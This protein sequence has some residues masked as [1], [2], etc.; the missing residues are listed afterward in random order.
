[1]TTKPGK[2]NLFQ[3]KFQVKTGKLL[4]GTLDQSYFPKDQL[5]ENKLTK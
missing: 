2:C 1:M 5:S 4:L 3:Y